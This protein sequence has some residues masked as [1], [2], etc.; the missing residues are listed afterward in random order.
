MTASADT[1]NVQERI[2]SQPMSRYQMWVVFLGGLILFI[3]G[4]DVQLV[5]YIGPKILTEWSIS[6]TMLGTIFS[7]MIWGLLIGF[8]FVAPLSI[9][10]GHRPLVLINMVLFGI[11]TMA[12]CFVTEPTSMIALRV[13]AGIGL[14]GVIPSGVAMTGEFSPKRRRSTCIAL[15]Y[16]GYSFGTMAAGLLAGVIIE[17]YGWRTHMV[18]G[19]V[20]PLVIAA[21]LYFTLP[22]SPEFLVSKGAPQSVIATLMRRIAPATPITDATKFTV[23]ETRETSLALAQL[24]S[25]G[26]TL[27]T[28]MLWLAL[29]MNLMVIFFVLQWLPSI[30]RMVGYSP[31][32][33]TTAATWASSGGILAALILGPLMDRFGPYRV[34][35]VLFMIGAS[36]LFFTGI[37]AHSAAI[38]ATSMAFVA[39]GSI[40]G[41]QK[42]INALMVFFYPTALRST[43]LGWAFGIGRFGAMIGPVLAGF[44][45]DRQW[46]VEEVFNVYAIPM[47]IGG[48]AILIMYLSYREAKAAPVAS[49]QPAATQ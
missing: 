38:L 5:S 4:L 39:L 31:A 45:F 40:S 48:L 12:A 8:A 23:T 3:D 35:V 46:P 33:A 19:G 41:I 42:C 11:A 17:Q 43:G 6:R 21:F 30:F 2:E 16:C 20:I 1:L 14:A 49:A 32:E 44:L 37:S 10:F 34:I 13:L 47:V 7:S 25:N 18:I 26:R 29:F 15:I 28:L 9:R 24:F 36:F 22:E 27:G